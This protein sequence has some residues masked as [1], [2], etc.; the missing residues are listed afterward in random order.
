[1]DNMMETKIV[2]KNNVSG[3]DI[4]LTSSKLIE[5]VN[6][7]RIIF[8]RYGMKTV[9]NGLPTMFS[10]YEIVAVNLY[11]KGDI[12]YIMVNMHEIEKETF[13]NYYLQGLKDGN[14]C[15]KNRIIF[16]F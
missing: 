6:S 16:S 11:D 4:V 3:K 15:L 14:F 8:Y 10:F 5:I 1:M 13:Y 9:R 7:Y 2:V 12:F